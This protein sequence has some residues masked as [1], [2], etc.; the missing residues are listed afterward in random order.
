MSQRELSKITYILDFG[1]NVNH[2]L[3]WFRRQ[4]GENMILTIN[5]SVIGN[6]VKKYTQNNQWV[7]ETDEL[8]IYAIPFKVLALP[9]RIRGNEIIVETKE[10]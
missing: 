8:E 3:I 7:F 5:G 9:P 1:K 10:A 4:E 6:V 2:S